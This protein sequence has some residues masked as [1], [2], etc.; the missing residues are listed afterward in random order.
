MTS[1]QMR[2]LHIFLDT[3]GDSAVSSEEGVPFVRDLAS[4]HFTYDAARV[5]ALMDADGDGALTFVE[6]SDDLRQTSL[7]EA[8]KNDLI[9]RF[10]EFDADGDGLLTPA[11]AAPLMCYMFHMGKLD[12]DGDGA[13]DYEEF[14]QVAAPKLEG[15]S[16]KHVEQSA[17]EGRDIFVG[18]DTDGDGRLDA[19]EYFLYESGVYA[20]VVAWKMLFDLAD[21]DE[22][23]GVTAEELVMVRE[24][25]KFAGSAAYH[26][27]K[28]WI[29]KIE[30]I[31]RHAESEAKER[32]TE[33]SD[34]TM[35]L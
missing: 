8:R 29:E 21:A 20:G 28:S 11:E 17:R 30:K 34:E 32:T 1:D 27:S 7:E 25:P 23:G 13:L 10:A 3:D 6:F 24:H 19:R 14:A 22:D 35:E 16:Q 33:N 5:V 15:R 26:H 4:S 2:T 31:A 18:L 12:A 9:G